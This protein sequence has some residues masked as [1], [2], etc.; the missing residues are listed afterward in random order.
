MCQFAFVQQPEHQS[1]MISR[2]N[3]R[4]MEP[5]FENIVQA[6]SF[7]NIL[8]ESHTVIDQTPP[9]PPQTADIKTVLN[10]SVPKIAQNIMLQPLVDTNENNIV[11]SS[12]SSMVGEANVT[13]LSSNQIQPTQP[14]PMGPANGSINGLVQTMNDKLTVRTN[15]KAQQTPP[16]AWK[17]KTHSV[18]VSVVPSN[19]YPHNEVTAAKQI[20]LGSNNSSSCSNNNNVPIVP[21]VDDQQ[22]QSSKLNANA[23][24][25]ATEKSVQSTQ[26]VTTQ[27]SSEVQTVPVSDMQQDDPSIFVNH[28]NLR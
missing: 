19:N 15:S 1:H 17:I 7:A 28:E 26:D 14:K 12:S 24:S 23:V 21:K 9:P 18:A 22:Q 11:S 3:N 27:Q 6:P 13:Q 8:N 2:D 20:N 10:N 4:N 5:I 16:T 25:I